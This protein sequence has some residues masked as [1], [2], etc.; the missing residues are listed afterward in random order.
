M[1]ERVQMA[2]KIK[3]SKSQKHDVDINGDELDS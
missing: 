2:S 1:Y 3:V